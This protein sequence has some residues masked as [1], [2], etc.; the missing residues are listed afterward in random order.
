M[1]TIPGPVDSVVVVGAGLSGLAAALY[2][3]GAGKRVTVLERDDTVGGRV[4][5]YPVYDDSGNPLYT[6]DNGASVLTMPDL[7]SDA[8]AAVGESFDSTTPTVELSALSPSYHARYADGSALDVYADPTEMSAEVEKVCGPGEVDGYRRLRG[9]LASIFDT[10][11]DRYIASNFDSPLDLVGSRAALRDTARLAL[12]GGFGR[13]GS[14]IASFVRDDR[15]RRIFTF[16]SLYAGV[17]P[18]KALGVYGAIAHMD[19]SLGV[20]FPAGGMSAVA[21]S[22]ADA[23][24]RHG[25]ALHTSAEVSE[26]EIR[27]DRVTA[28]LTSDGR[29]VECDALVL[30]PDL[31]IV[32]RL[33]DRAGVTSSGRKRGYSVVSPSAVVFHGTVPT[34]VTQ[35]W[36]SSAHHTIDFGEQWAETFA[37]ITAGPGRG[38]LMEDPSLLITRPAVTDPA[39]RMVRNGVLSEPVSILAPCPNLASAPIDWNRRAVPYMRE[40]QIVLEQR[41]YRG[42]TAAM[43]VDHLDTPQTWRDKGMLEGSPFSSAHVFRQTG[44]FRRKNMVGG[45][46]NVV[47]AGSG[48]TPGVGVPTVLVSG[49]LAAERIVGSATSERPRRTAVTQSVR[50]EEVVEHG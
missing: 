37:R 1:K 33:L 14:R 15:L 31:P 48:T 6:I 49:R 4:G 27:N 16:Q 44:P 40:I 30:T 38:Q 42:L 36:P 10:E 19:T 25:G 8:L 18:S 43:V 22:M 34:E 11:F 32:D 20:Y 47:L 26:L 3:T 46:D 41:G 35:S 2:L 23:L 28:V 29:R 5:T 9:W 45:V 50:S 24:T 13:L 21:E 12:I 17:A 7:I 39:L